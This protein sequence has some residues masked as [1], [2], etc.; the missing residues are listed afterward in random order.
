MRFR[1][2]NSIKC[3]SCN[4]EI[5]NYLD[6]CPYCG[7]FIRSRR[8][9][10]NIWITI[11][12][13]FAEP[14]VTMKDI[15]FVKRKSGMFILF[16]FTILGL[17]L[18][19]FIY[20]NFQ[21][22]I[23]LGVHAFLTSFW[24]TF[25]EMIFLMF[26]YSILSK[27]LLGLIGFKARIKDLWAVSVYSFVPFILSLFLLL[28]IEIGLFGEFWFTF[29]PYPWIIKSFPAYFL[30]FVHGLMLTW[31]LILFYIGLKSIYMN[32]LIALT[33]WLLFIVLSFYILI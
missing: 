26:S 31:S 5:P 6:T 33:S 32:F 12:N 17:S 15:I 2:K 22:Q 24:L 13:L 21:A 11:F 18:L 4:K 3:N 7:A 14:V 27:F 23:N 29:H 8:N 1:I 28:P 16:L 20:L 19:N 25:K 10:L 30:L 9:N